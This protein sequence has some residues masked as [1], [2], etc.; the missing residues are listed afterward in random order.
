MIM[1]REEDA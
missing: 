1:N